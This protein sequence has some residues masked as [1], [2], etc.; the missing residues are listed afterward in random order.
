MVEVSR[1]EQER[2]GSAHNAQRLGT[3]PPLLRHALVALQ[4]TASR[5]LCKFGWPAWQDYLQQSD[6]KE[7]VPRVAMTASERRPGEMRPHSGHQDVDLGVP[8]PDRCRQ[9][10]LGAH[11]AVH[12]TDL[13]WLAAHAC[14]EVQQILLVGVRRIA[15]ED[16][17]AG[18]NRVALTIEIDMTAARAVFAGCPGPAC[19]RPGSR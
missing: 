19:L 18:A 9:R 14:D 6:R 15:A 3:W 2:S 1:G 7:R 4:R 10:L 11:V 8:L 16:V 12:Q 17:N 13:P 5:R